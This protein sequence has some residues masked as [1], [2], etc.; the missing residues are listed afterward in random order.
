MVQEYQDTRAEIRGYV[1]D[2]VEGLDEV[3]T[4]EL[5]HD[6]LEYY[7]D[8]LN[9][10]QSFWEQNA[11]LVVRQLIIQELEQTAK[12]LNRNPKADGSPPV[13]VLQNNGDP[14]VALSTTLDEEPEA[15]SAFHAW[16]LRIS[17]GTRI[18]L[19]AATKPQLV[20]NWRH[21]L[22]H[23]RGDRIKIL[24]E[25]RVAERLPD[26]TTPVGDVLSDDE[27]A[28]LW[29]EADEKITKEDQQQ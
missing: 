24:F 25:Q 3:N 2:Q 8:D 19:T 1:R 26:D 13:R 17:G 16:F 23:I 9:F 10:M 22:A 27:L 29:H 21:R 15:E 20:E 11:P 14:T 28:E 6:V 12:A 4:L 7:G 5:S 18:R